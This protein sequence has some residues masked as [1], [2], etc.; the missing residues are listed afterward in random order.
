MTVL[1]GLAPGGRGRAP[2]HLAAMMARSTGEPVVVCA[3]AP[4]PWPPGIARIDAEYRQYMDEAARQVLDDA[5]QR[6]ADDIQASF[7]TVHARSAPSGL[8]EA[9]ERHDAS[10]IVVG[11]SSAGMFG[12]VSLGSVSDRLLHSSRVPVALAPRGFRCRPGAR[13][14]RVTAAFGGTPEA[15]ELVVAAA[16]VAAR[17]GATLRLASF[18]VRARPPYTSG[19]G[20]EADASMQAEWA[21]ELEAAAARTLEGVRALPAVPDRLE[22]VIGHGETWA[23]A[24]E[25]VEWTD[26]DVLVVGSSAIGPV[27]RVFLGSRASK[28]VR[29]SPVP[30]VVVPRGAAHELAEQAEHPAVESA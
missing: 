20:R 11:S 15:D 26:G 13:V 22:Q 25:D 16:G 7:E 6:L 24:L 10:V 23:E 4:A 19:V 1:V 30:V 12:H 29:H 17:V 18:A 2:V 5:R 9:A 28:I 8:M 14:T 27:A 21:R 3:V